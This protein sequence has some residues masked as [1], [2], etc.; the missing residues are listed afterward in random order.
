MSKRLVVTVLVLV[1]MA[2][3]SVAADK[4]KDGS[5]TGWVTCTHCG[6]KGENPKHAGCATKCV[7]EMGAKW[8]LYTPSDKKVYTLVGADDKV[9]AQAGKHVKVS[10]SVEGANITVASIEPAGEQKGQTK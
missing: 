5:W 10:G 1:F 4:G 6:A 7:N 3:L 2:G 9:S 8:A